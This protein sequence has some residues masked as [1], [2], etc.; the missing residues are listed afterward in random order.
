MRT[1]SSSVAAWPSSS[2]A[3][4]TT[5]APYRFTT[6]AWRMN[7]SSPT[8][9]E[10]ELTM[11]LPCTTLRPASTTWNL[12]ESIMKGTLEMSGSVTATRRNLVIIDS[13]STMPSSTLMSSTIAPSST[14]L[15]ATSIMPATSFVFTS[16]LNCRLPAMLHRSPTLRK[17]NRSLVTVRSSRPLRRITGGLWP[18]ARGWCFASSSATRLMC[19]GVEPQQPPPRFRK[20]ERANSP[21]SSPIL[22]GESS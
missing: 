15:R 4:T 18:H 12:D 11:H 9:S 13:P 10:M 7:S 19:G 14:C 5:A 2:K 16:R 1:F 22:S 3:M 21:T 17:L 8:L 20:P 6:R